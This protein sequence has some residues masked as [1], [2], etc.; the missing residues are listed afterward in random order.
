MTCE[1]SLSRGNPY[2]SRRKG[3]RTSNKKGA[4]PRSRP[5]RVRLVCLRL[6]ASLPFR[7]RRP[8]RCRGRRLFPVLRVVVSCRLGRLRF[9]LGLLVVFCRRR[10]LPRLTR[11][12]VRRVRI[13]F[14]FLVLV[15]GRRWWRRSPLLITF[16]T[17]SRLIVVV[18]K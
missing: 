17:P 9:P 13:I 16:V 11:V 5:P 4:P 8:Y 15:D 1:R 14:G 10:R 2:W 18:P 12:L 6:T 3:T 7:Y